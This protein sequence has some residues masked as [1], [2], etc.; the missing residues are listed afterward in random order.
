M[1]AATDAQVPKPLTYT[2]MYHFLWCILFLL[3]A[4]T[5]LGVFLASGRGFVEGV[6]PPLILVALGLIA[7]A[8]FLATYVLR[9]QLL[10]GKVTWDEAFHWSSRSSWAVLIFAPILFAAWKVPVVGVER[11]LL[12]LTGQDWSVPVQMTLTM[13]EVEVVV[14]WISHL[15]SVRG[16]A[17]GRKRYLAPD[18]APPLAAGASLAT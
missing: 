8:G 9:V 5:L 3:S 11:L 7:G 15:L 16:L 6:L 2:L 1:P 18:A 13:A 4:L 14:W 10:L 17:K 12:T